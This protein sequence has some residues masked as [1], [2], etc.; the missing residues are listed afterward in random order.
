MGE[1]S[2]EKG[3]KKGGGIKVGKRQKKEG[4]NG[5]KS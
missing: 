3:K 4:R 1:K 5:A 2:Q